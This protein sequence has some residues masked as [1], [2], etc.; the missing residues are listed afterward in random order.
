MADQ[1]YGYPGSVNAAAWASLA[2]NVG[3][4]QYSVGGVNDCKVV[5][6]A[7]ADRGIEIKPGTITGDGVMDKFDNPTFLAHSA[8]ASGADRW[9]MV[10]LRRTWNPTPGAS[11]YVY[12]IITGGTNKSL[13]ARNNTKGALAD[14][15]IALCRIKAGSSVVQEI[16][17]LRVWAHNGGATANDELVMTYLNDP[18]TVITI[19]TTQFDR[20]EW[21]R[22]V[23]KDGAAYWRPGTASLYGIGPS[24]FGGSPPANAGMLIQA[25]STVH[26]T[27]SAGYA[28]ITWPKQFPNGLLTVILTNGD[29]WATA[30]AHMIVEGNNG[31]WGVSGN[32]SKWDVVYMVRN[33]VGSNE[34]ARNTWH[35]VNWI[36]IGW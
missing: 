27:D 3:A 12:T 9:D 24:I 31:F 23:D 1:H 17:D 33:W 15:P 16:V 19:G 28:R 4:A 2:P 7:H 29:S 21:H 13:P 30:G 5:T 25:G 10:V 18:G 32:G 14:Q 6:S 20:V 35:R 36:A 8:V 26:R 34:M 22:E 11:T